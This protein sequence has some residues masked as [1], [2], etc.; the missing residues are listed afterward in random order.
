MPTLIVGRG[1]LYDTVSSNVGYTLD[2]RRRFVYLRG[3]FASAIGPRRNVQLLV[4]H[5]AA[6]VLAERAKATLRLVDTA[7]GLDVEACLDDHPEAAGI[8]ARIERG[9]LRAM[10]VGTLEDRLLGATAGADQ[11]V[12]TLVVPEVDELKEVSLA[13]EGVFGVGQT[14]VGLKTVTPQTLQAWRRVAWAEYLGE[15]TGTDYF[16]D[17]LAVDRAL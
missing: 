1:A 16:R 8:L 9:E 7:K 14:F 3:A 10:S 17:T 2:G 6:P 4:H 12:P 11:A 15:T 13:V 5:E